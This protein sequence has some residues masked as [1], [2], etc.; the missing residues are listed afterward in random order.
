MDAVASVEVYLRQTA[1]LY[2]WFPLKNALVDVQNRASG[3]EHSQ[4]GWENYL[5]GNVSMIADVASV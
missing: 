2:H 4:I 5:K 1:E 3:R